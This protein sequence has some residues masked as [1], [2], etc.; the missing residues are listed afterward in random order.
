MMEE[1][2]DRGTKAGQASQVGK[3]VWSGGESNHVE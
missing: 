2:G 3:V 1:E